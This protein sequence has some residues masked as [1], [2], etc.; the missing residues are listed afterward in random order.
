MKDPIILWVIDILRRDYDVP[1]Q[2]IEVGSPTEL[3]LSRLHQGRAD[4][5]IYDD[6]FINSAGNFYVAFI[7]VEVMDLGKKFG[8]TEG[9]GNLDFYD[10]LSTSMSLFPSARYAILTS[11]TNTLIYRRGPEYTLLEKIG[12]LPQ[13]QSVRQA[14]EHNPY[15][16]VLNQ[17]EPD[18]IQTGLRPLTKDTFR[19]VLGDTH[20]GCY[21]ILRDIEG[22][23]PQ[24]A[25]EAIVKFLFAKWYD[26]Q[27]TIDLAKR[28]I[29][30]TFTQNDYF[31]ESH[32][33]LSVGLSGPRP[34][35]T[36]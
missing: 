26:E 5:I 29:L 23:Q 18:G 2:A 20:S 9:E 27:A 14:A 30:L 24:E 21:A 25:V 17:D 6:R 3:P 11:R 1:L 10:H 33:N 34:K 16:V 28:T 13:Y 19:K 7:L 32:E 8:G 4:L 12:E 15:K 22:L 36:T 31:P 35:C